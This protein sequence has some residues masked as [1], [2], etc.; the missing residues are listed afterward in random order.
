MEYHDIKMKE[1]NRTIREMWCNTY[2]GTDIDTI[3]ICSKD[4]DESN[5]ATPNS[6][7]FTSRQS[8]KYSVVMLRNGTKVNMRGCCSAGQKVFK[9]RVGKVRVWV[10]V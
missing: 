1:V 9:L 8:Y 10:N 7:A 6:D 3:E 5:K 2:G 4:S